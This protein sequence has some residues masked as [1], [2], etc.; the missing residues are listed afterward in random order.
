MMSLD[1][2][3]FPEHNENEFMKRGYLL[4]DGCKDLADALKAK[5][6]TAFEI[7]FKADAIKSLKSITPKPPLQGVLTIPTKI[8]LSRLATMIDKKPLQIVKD[9]MK[10]GIFFPLNEELEQLDSEMDFELISHIARMYGFLTK[11]ADHP[12]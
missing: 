5:R 7:W 4:P 1:S 9:L 12:S 10:L 3:N 2:T 6:A 8:S 11:R